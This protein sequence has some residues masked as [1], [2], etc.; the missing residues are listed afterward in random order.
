MAVRAGWV[1]LALPFGM[2][3]PPRSSSLESELG[4]A[5]QSAFRSPN[6][7][8]RAKSCECESPS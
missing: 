2:V 8:Q 6:A 7:G 3:V 4:C 1:V 5:G